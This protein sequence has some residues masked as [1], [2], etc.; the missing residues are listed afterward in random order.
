MVLPRVLSERTNKRASAQTYYTQLHIQFISSIFETTTITKTTTRTA[1]KNGHKWQL[2]FY[3]FYFC[4]YIGIQ[5]Y[6]RMTAIIH[7]F[8]P[9]HHYHGHLYSRFPKLYSKINGQLVLF[10]F[11]VNFVLDIFESLHFWF[12]NR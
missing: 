12:V 7:T 2:F 6:N 11:R 5:L 4:I 9:R 8:C 10:F 1:R 3:Y